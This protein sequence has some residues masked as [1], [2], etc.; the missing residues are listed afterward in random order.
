[1]QLGYTTYR[2][3]PT[4]VSERARATET[5]SAVISTATKIWR[6]ALGMPLVLLL[7]KENTRLSLSIVSLLLLLLPVCLFL[8][9]SLPFTLYSTVHLCTISSMSRIDFIYLG[10][11]KQVKKNICVKTS[12]ATRINIH[13]AP[14]YRNTVIGESIFSYSIDWKFYYVILNYISYVIIRIPW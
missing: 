14:F 13:F 4:A 8:P 6:S 11:S 2:S 7:N 1:M 9:L 10:H 3:L 5:L 12:Y